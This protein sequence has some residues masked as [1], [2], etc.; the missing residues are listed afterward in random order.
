MTETPLVSVIVPT[1]DRPAALRDCLRALEAQTFERYEIVV[2]DD[3]SRD[4]RSVATIV[5]GVARARLVRADGR[6]PAAARNRGAAAATGPFLCFT[7]DD[8]APSPAWIASMHDALADGARAV[9]GPTR[10]ATTQNR[11]AAASQSITNHLVESSFDPARASV[12]FAPTSNLACA[13]TTWQDVPF[14]EDYPAAAGEDR[15]WCSR[16]RALGIEIRYASSAT[17]DHRPDLSARTFWRQQMRYGRG[18]HRWQRSQPA[19]SRRQP[20][21]FYLGLVRRARADGNPVALL[22]VLAQLA[23][24][25]GYGREALDTR[26]RR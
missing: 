24:A 18:A 12:S 26:R 14:D 20:A 17:V 21:R 22:V 19:G 11:Y 4:A 9:A 2:V 8:C 1:R 7:D 16:A 13:V 23:T 25:I 10:N 3:G 6:G 5:E 15:D